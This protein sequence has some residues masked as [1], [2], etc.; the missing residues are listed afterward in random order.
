MLLEVLVV[1]LSEEVDL[2][3]AVVRARQRGHVDVVVRIQVLGEVVP[4]PH[5]V[6]EAALLL[7]ENLFFSGDRPPFDSAM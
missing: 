3:L 6:A 7:L 4:L 5:A 1:G 2:I